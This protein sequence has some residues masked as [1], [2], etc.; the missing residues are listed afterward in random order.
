MIIKGSKENVVLTYSYK[1]SYIDSIKLINTSGKSFS[2][3]DTSITKNDNYYLIALR[4]IIISVKQHIY[5][6]K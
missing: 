1:T 5:K 2:F 4:L 3:T 6:Y